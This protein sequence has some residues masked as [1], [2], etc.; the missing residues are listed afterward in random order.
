MFQQF[1]VQLISK[2][3]ALPDEVEKALARVGLR[4]I[5]R[6]NNCEQWVEAVE[7]VEIFHTYS[8]R[9]ANAGEGFGT[10][11]DTKETLS[12]VEIANLCCRSCIYTKKAVLAIA[13]YSHCDHCITK[14][15]LSNTDSMLL[16]KLASDLIT[17]SN[18]E[19]PD[20]AASVLA[21]TQQVMDNDTFKLLLNKTLLSLLTSEQMKPIKIAN[22]ISELHGSF[23]G[24]PKSLLPNTTRSLVKFYAANNQWVDARKYFEEG[25]NMK[26]Y[27]HTFFDSQ[28]FLA[29]IKTEMSYGEIYLTIESH[30]MQ[31]VNH[32]IFG[33]GH[34]PLSRPVDLVV[35]P[36]ADVD[37]E[38]FR[39]TLQH[40][41]REIG[42]ALTKEFTPPLQI[43][44]TSNQVK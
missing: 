28:P 31:L 33:I 2:F 44:E 30:L 19:C 13:V 14:D 11:I 41:M 9:Y 15:N 39:L 8:I 34:K 6:F 22:Q 23:K 25:R 4:L 37:G 20:Q 36:G 1:V 12:F 27:Q 16:T 10:Q 17:I 38:Q 18:V 42:R 24:K 35:A 32:P 7:T 3:D 40:T 21:K 43:L 29:E 26:V 5:K